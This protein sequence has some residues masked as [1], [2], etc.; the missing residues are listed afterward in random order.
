MNVLLD[1]DILIEV[2]RMRDDA[3]LARWRELSV[4]DTLI[5]YSP[6]SAAEVWTGARPR[7]HKAIEFCFNSLICAAMDY[8]TG[9]LA[10]DLM[11]QYRK[12][13]SLEIGD[14]LI[15]ATAIR[16]QAQ[17]W[18]RNRKHYPMPQLRFF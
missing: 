15:A 6:V 2:L 12:S 1:S 10:G 8:E 3:L 18:T 4:S 11:R 16:N 9:H 17:L 14:A 7:E 13:H 5:L